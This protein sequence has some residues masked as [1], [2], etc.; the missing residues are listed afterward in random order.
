[1]RNDIDREVAER[2]VRYRLL[3]VPRKS[4]RMCL[5]AGYSLWETRRRNTHDGGP[6]DI[7]FLF[8]PE[9]LVQRYD[10]HAVSPEAIEADAYAHKQQERRG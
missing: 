1:M 3:K 7:V 9:E 4:M 8:S 2:Q 6:Q 10:A 5:P